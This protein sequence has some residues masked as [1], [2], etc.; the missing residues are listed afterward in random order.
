[1]KHFLLAVIFTS[2]LLA[3]DIVIEEAVPAQEEP[4]T[5]VEET[6]QAE[7]VEEAVAEEAVQEETVAEEVVQEE[8]VAD[9]TKQE[10]KTAE[11]TSAEK[12]TPVQDSSKDSTTVEEKPAA[13]VYG[14]KITTTPDS[15]SVKINGVDRGVTPLTL[16]DINEGKQIVV[17]KKKGYFG[18]K[19]TAETKKDSLSEV[20]VTL[21][22]PGTITVA[23]NPDSAIIFMN[24]KKLESTPYTLTKL[25][26][27]DYN[28]TLL[29]SGFS[30]F[31]TTVTVD[32]GIND[33]LFAELESTAAKKVDTTAAVEA[34]TQQT[35][36]TTEPTGP[37]ELT[38]ESK[39]KKIFT[40]IGGALFAIFL[41][42]IIVSEAAGE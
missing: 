14:L 36:T 34:S 8:T 23:S 17:L 35:L 33:T 42:G 13:G 15:V 39:R 18:K 20:N 38:T 3:Q 40:I 27:G 37:V 1:M 2:S 28:F 10:E 21:R 6:V 25:R 11:T 19:V 24:K 7:V 16:T 22:A 29:K 30:R 5:V 26:P 4:V 32:E 41:T 12:V 9:T 31:D